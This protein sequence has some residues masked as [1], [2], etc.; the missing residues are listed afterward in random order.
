MSPIKS[1]LYRAQL[2]RMWVERPSQRSPIWRFSLEDVETKERN[3]FA[4]LDA[5]IDHLLRLM[6][7]CPE[8]P[9]ELE[10]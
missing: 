4:D 1:P 9:A 8:Q 2:L 6:A 3:G 5:L 10:W 7:E